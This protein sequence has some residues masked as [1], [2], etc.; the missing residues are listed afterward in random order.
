MSP[1]SSYLLWLPPQW[2]IHPVFHI[3]LLTPYHETMTHGDNYLHPP[4]ELVD[5]EEEYEVEAI[6]DSRTFGRGHKLQ[7]LIKW[8]GYP[9]ADNQWEDANNVHS[10]DLVHQF[11]K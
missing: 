3:N 4:P 10:D 11:Q 9:D 8:K 1:V 2:K 7:Y 5:N 6:L